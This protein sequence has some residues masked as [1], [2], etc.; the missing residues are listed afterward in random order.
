MTPISKLNI[1]RLKLLLLHP[2]ALSPSARSMVVD[3][4]MLGAACKHKPSPDTDVNI[5]MFFVWLAKVNPRH[6]ETKDRPGYYWR[7]VSLTY[8]LPLK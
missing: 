1:R 4:L 6:K 7:Y 5:T 8:G 3:W 2:T